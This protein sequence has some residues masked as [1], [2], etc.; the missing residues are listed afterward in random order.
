M[1]ETEILEHKVC[2]RPGRS[3]VRVERENLAGGVPSVH[4]HGHGGS[5]VTLSR[6]CAEEVTGLV[7]MRWNGEAQARQRF[8]P[9]EAIIEG[10]RRLSVPGCCWQGL[11][12]DLSPLRYSK[13]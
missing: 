13:R 10:E 1:T 5:G 3:E 6:G 2:L 11:R 12:R 8:L 9:C 4:N 7:H